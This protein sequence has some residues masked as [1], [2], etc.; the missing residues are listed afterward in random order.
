MNKPLARII[1]KKKRQTQITSICNECEGITT[2]FADIKWI[3]RE[4]Y[5]QF[6]VHAFGNSDE[7]KNYLKD[8]N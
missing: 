2:N 5:G 6:Y 8:T 1:K 3:V 7:M 4:N